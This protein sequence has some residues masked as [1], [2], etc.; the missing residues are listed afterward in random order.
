[1]ELVASQAELPGSDNRAAEHGNAS[2]A[3]QH[4]G[5]GI[6]LESE[7]VGFEFDPSGRITDLAQLDRGSG[8]YNHWG[9]TTASA[10]ISPAAATNPAASSV[11]PAHG[12]WRCWF[13]AA[14]RAA[15]EP[16]QLTIDGL[17]VSQS[18]RRW[19]GQFAQTSRW[20]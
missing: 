7:A 5:A 16:N 20:P 14:G 3:L 6:V 9:T 15:F 1:L 10:K 13:A 18:T 19:S 4:G 12:R 17:G 11:Q 2:K 8:G